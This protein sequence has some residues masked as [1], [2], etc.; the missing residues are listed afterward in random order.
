MAETTHDPTDL[1]AAAFPERIPAATL[2]RLPLEVATEFAA[3]FFAETDTALSLGVAHPELLKSNLQEA[4]RVLEGEV[5]KKIVLYR[6]TAGELRRALKYY[7]T[8]A[9]EVSQ[10]S[11]PPQTDEKP[12]H[13]VPGS[14]VSAALLARIP[15]EYAKE[16]RLLAV[17]IE[18]NGTV[19]FATD[20]DN[21]S[22]RVA[23][24]LIARRN[25]FAEKIVT[26]PRTEFERLLKEQGKPVAPKPETTPTPPLKPQSE[27]NESKG[28]TEPDYKG[29][30]LTGEVEKPGFAGLFQRAGQLIA[31]NPAPV[32]VA[33]P[34]VAVPASVPKSA[35]TVAVPPL[36]VL[37]G[38]SAKKSNEPAPLSVPAVPSLSSV[39]KASEAAP[40]VSEA[41]ISEVDAST[42]NEE[43]GTNREDALFARPVSDVQ[44][45]QHIVRAG[46]IPR[47]VAGVINLAVER[48]ASDVHL[49]PFGD[50]LLVRYR[51]DGQLSEILR[52]PMS[53]H[54][55]MVS[56]IKILSK[57]KLDESRIPQDGRFDVT[58]SG[59]REIDIRVSTLPTVH[60]EKVVMR[61]LDK[62]EGIYS[63]EKLGLAGDG[64]NRL[65]GSIK[66]AYGVVLST[67][68]TG[69]G[70]TTTLYAIL[71]R[72]ATTNVN[73]ITLED[74][75]EYEMKGINQSQIKPKIGFTFAEGLRSVLRQDPNIIMVGEIRDGETAAMATHAALTGHLV[76]STLHTNNAAG[77]L[78]RLINMGIEPFLITSAMNA[79]VGQRL[80]RRL[81]PECKAKF[82]LP[83]AVRNEIDGELKLIREQS[84][85][86][87]D[88]IPSEIA[89]YRSKGCAKCTNGYRGR[90]GLFEVLLMSERIEDLAVRKAPAVEIEKVAV[91]EGMLTM[92]QDG[93][94]KVLSGLTTLDEVLRETTSR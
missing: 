39:P 22:L 87:T 70:K 34:T 57:L 9:A 73:V 44:Q 75:V 56:R 1:P 65:V 31:G 16:H 21:P 7:K 20:R 15:F 67:G 83:A 58:V 5:G 90:I 38:A 27:T 53:V 63:L 62:S 10:T 2:L 49:E 86:E 28:I 60:G 45:L 24:E 61:L 29:T 64:F 85:K 8:A 81:C 74:P 26:V 4:L 47:I 48:K 50:E 40:M 84:P 30:I 3:V 17:D 51:V 80:V 68:P 89:F 71:Q 32:P 43:S 6:I 13:Y 37:P 36:P 25:R 23:A 92:K 91:A 79:V 93:I 46:S 11:E 78:P 54:A 66:Q 72:V 77:A 94:L 42:E 69:S 82:E 41:G 52:L 19:W 76:L 88:R 12:P 59:N 14:A 33:A 35:S 55:A 18:R